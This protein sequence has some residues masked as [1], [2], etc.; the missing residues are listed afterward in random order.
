MQR[1]FL[2]IVALAI[3]TVLQPSA[4]ATTPRPASKA[5]PPPTFRTLEEA[6]QHCSRGIIWLGEVS[7]VSPTSGM[8]QGDSVERTMYMCASRTNPE[9]TTMG[10]PWGPPGWPNGPPDPCG[11]H[12]CQPHVT[13]PPS[14]PH[15]PS[16]PP[17]PEPKPTPQPK[18]T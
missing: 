18:K 9:I 7:N 3:V 13:L 1:F 16:A 5:T 10:P 4:L 6:K 14:N 17:K 15:K 2:I 12:G 8:A 11:P